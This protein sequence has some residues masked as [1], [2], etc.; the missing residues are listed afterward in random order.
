M[1]EKEI[2]NTVVVEAFNMIYKPQEEYQLIKVV[3][4]DRI[5]HIGYAL[6]HERN[7]VICEFYVS[8]SGVYEASSKGDLLHSNYEIKHWLEFITLIK[9]ELR[10]LEQESEDE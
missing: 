6:I 4:F 8:D 1:L 3:E 5:N 7:G 10:K 2:I 9:E